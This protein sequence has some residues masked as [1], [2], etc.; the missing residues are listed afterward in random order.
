VPDSYSGVEICSYTEALIDYDDQDSISQAVYDL[1]TNLDWDNNGKINIDIKEEDLEIEV[2][3]VD[4]VPY[5]WGP[6]IVEIKTWQ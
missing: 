1:L 6:A 4:Q 2:L 3:W 5:L